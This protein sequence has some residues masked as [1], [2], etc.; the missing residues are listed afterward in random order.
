MCPRI[1][2]SRAAPSESRAENA[3]R[4]YRGKAFEGCDARGE[5]IPRIS[6][7]TLFYRIERAEQTP[8]LA[9]ANKRRQLLATR[10]D[11]YAATGR[12]VHAQSTA[13]GRAFSVG[14]CRRVPIGHITVARS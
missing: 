8:G 1:I 9:T 5:E 6:L 7:E 4:R 11:E 13:V 2:N 3:F 10:R 14:S 12:Q